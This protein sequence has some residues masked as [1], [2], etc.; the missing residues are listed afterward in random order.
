LA[1]GTSSLLGSGQGGKTV[2]VGASG[3]DFTTIQA[4]IDAAPD[5]GIIEVQNR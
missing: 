2:T 4:A 1:V 5:G 3:C